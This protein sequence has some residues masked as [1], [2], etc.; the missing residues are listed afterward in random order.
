MLSLDLSV[1]LVQVLDQLLLLRLL[2]EHGRHVFAEGVD[3]VGVD[4]RQSEKNQK[5][6]LN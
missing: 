5:V 1:Q 3:D 2:A 4:F 6:F